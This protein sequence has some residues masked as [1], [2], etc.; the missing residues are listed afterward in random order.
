MDIST[1]RELAV[2]A[3]HVCVGVTVLVFLLAGMAKI[4]QPKP[5]VG[6][7]R[8]YKILATGRLLP[9]VAVAISVLEVGL[10]VLMMIYGRSRIIA[11]VCATMLLVF[12][13]A[14]AVNLLQGRRNTPCGC[15]LLGKG[16]VS[17]GLVFR[18]LELAGVAFGGTSGGIAIA[19]ITI[20]F[21]VICGISAAKLAPRPFTA[22]VSP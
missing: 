11:G 5:F 21:S 22:E 14:M 10:R 15:G 9:L 19:G 7:L 6:A 16:A 4:L 8:T 12:A 17:W 3:R 13:V 2:W 18:N 1:Q 20:F